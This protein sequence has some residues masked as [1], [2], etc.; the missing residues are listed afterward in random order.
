[1]E[2]KINS[3]DELEKISNKAKWQYFERLVSF[4]FEQNDFDV[5]H[6]VVLISKKKKR[7]YDVIAIKY[8]KTFVVECKKWRKNN[9][10]SLKRAIVDHKKKCN[11]YKRLTKQKNIIPIIVTLSEENIT[12]YENVIIVPIMKLNWFLNN[13]ENF[14]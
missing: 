11:F 9:I 4:I 14:Y 3:V 1:M 2:F 10:F 7:Q 8:D 5:K 12:A 6:N 13:Y